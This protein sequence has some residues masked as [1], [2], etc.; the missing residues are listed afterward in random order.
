MKRPVIFAFLSRFS[1]ALLNFVAIIVLSRF[2]GAEGRGIAGRLLAMISFIQILCD[3]MSGG[4]NV[5]LSSRFHSKS[6]IVPGWIWSACLSTAAVLVMYFFKPDYY[7]EFGFH[8]GILSFIC[9]TLYQHIHILSGREKFIESNRLIFIQSLLT[10]VSLLFFL[11]LKS[12]QNAYIL[13]LYC[14]WGLTWLI[15]LY[16]IYILPKDNSMVNVKKGASNLLS[17]GA[18]NQLGHLLQFSALRL[19]YF[20]LPLFSVGIFSNAVS[21]SESLWMIA[22]SIASIQYGI[23][24]NKNEGETAALLTARLLRITLI[25]TLMPGIIIGFLPGNF[26]ELIFGHQ[27]REISSDLAFLLPG[28]ILISGYLIIGHYFSGLGLFRMNNLALMAGLISSGL[29]LSI[30]L[31]LNQGNIDHKQA[32]LI[33][34]ISNSAVFFISLWLFSRHSGINLRD[35]LFKKDEY[36]MLLIRMKKLLT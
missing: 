5:Y 18:S 24:A 3:F 16:Y 8:L 19:F 7:S 12:S 30:I 13:S 6:L 27:F 32:A 1:A 2:L 34:G 36:T 15:S 29:G 31:Y 4:A 9:A 11:N 20:V 23:I 33:N 10:C 17:Y 35:L 22:S 26:F 28:T 14:G 21:L 25:L